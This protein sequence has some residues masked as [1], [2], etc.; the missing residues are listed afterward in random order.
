MEELR[1]DRVPLI[2]GPAL[3]LKL[4]SCHVE[5]CTE[6]LR[7]ASACLSYRSHMFLNGLDF[8]IR[9]FLASFKDNCDQMMN[10]DLA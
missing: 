4:N 3:L 2:S 5:N 8:K 9:Y 6:W 10:L 7:H 1:L